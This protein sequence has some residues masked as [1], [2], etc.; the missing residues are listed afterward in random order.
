MAF[1]PP[2][3]IQAALSGPWI[4]PWGDEPEPRAINS[5]RPALGSNQPRCPLAWAVNQTP[6]SGAGAT[7]WMPVR[8]GV[9]SGQDCI[10]AVWARMGPTTKAPAATT[11]ARRVI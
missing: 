10:L 9:P 7:S 5:V 1:C 8:R 11:A 2:S 4:T 3:V 6:P